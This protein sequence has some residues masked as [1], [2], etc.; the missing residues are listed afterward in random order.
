MDSVSWTFKQELFKASRQVYNPINSYESL[1][2]G[3]TQETSIIMPNDQVVNRV[4]NTTILGAEELSE[5]E[6]SSFHDLLQE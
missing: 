3:W 2:N 4:A 5:Q 1:T 6:K